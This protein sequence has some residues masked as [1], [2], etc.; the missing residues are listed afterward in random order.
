MLTFECFLDFF[1]KQQMINTWRSRDNA[2]SAS[3]MRT[4]SRLR[5]NCPV[6]V[7]LPWNEILLTPTQ[8]RPSPSY[9]SV[10]IICQLEKPYP[11]HLR[12][13][14]KEG[15]KLFT[16]SGEKKGQWSERDKAQRPRWRWHAI[17][18]G[19]E[20]LREYISR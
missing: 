9:R 4:L 7:N 16:D 11:Q 8:T 12:K 6:R 14:R 13:G 20:I 2:D 5:L 17:T 3:C 10:H 19:P 18:M 1:F 15:K